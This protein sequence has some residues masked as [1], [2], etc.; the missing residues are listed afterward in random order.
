MLDSLENL[1]PS[2]EHRPPLKSLGS[3]KNLSGTFATAV[4]P[5]A[6]ARRHHQY[7][8]GFK[9]FNMNILIE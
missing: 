9:D 7:S 6:I 5:F 2:C 8:P 3:L 4:F 1:S